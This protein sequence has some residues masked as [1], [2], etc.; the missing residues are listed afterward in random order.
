MSMGRVRKLETQGAPMSLRGQQPNGP[1]VDSFDD[2]I[3]D[4]F[5]FKSGAALPT[6]EL[7]F[8]KVALG[9]D[10]TVANDTTQRFTKQK[11][12]TNLKQQGQLPIDE[13]FEV[14]SIQ[15]KIM[16]GGAT[17]TTVSTAGNNIALP[18]DTAALAAVSGA[19]FLRALLDVTYLENKWINKVFEEGPAW[20]FPSEFG[21][22]G[23]V[24]AGA[25]TNFEAMW[26]NGF[27]KARIL[28]SPHLVRPQENFSAALNFFS[29]ITVPLDFRLQLI[30]RGRRIRSVQ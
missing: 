12:D 27:G 7:T 16:V 21:A 11:I 14:R 4:T 23:A 22:I 30:W 8:F 15:L 25:A 13:A 24:G 17:D 26:Q 9:N 28:A 1:V 2:I 5:R 20:A 10:A 6:S 19:N 18:T 3:F 29:P